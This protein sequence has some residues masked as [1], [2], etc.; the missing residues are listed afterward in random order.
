MI[1]SVEM[2][3]FLLLL[4]LISFMFVFLSCDDDDDDLVVNL[5]DLPSQSQTFL[6]THFP[7][8]TAV[9]VTKDDDSYDVILNNGFEVDFYLSGEWKSVDGHRTAIPESIMAIVPEEIS[10]YVTANFTNQSIIEISKE[11]YG[12]SVD[13]SSGIE[14]EFDINGSF[15]RIDT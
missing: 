5:M 1:K 13:L 10:T 4:G 2:K 12:F 9:R 8:Q 15:L 11:N 3:N 7:G 6:T 14:L